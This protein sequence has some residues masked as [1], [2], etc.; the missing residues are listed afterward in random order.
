MISAKV[1][2]DDL[3][4]TATEIDGVLALVATA[5][6]HAQELRAGIARLGVLDLP[7]MLDELRQKV[8]DATKQMASAQ[9]T[10]RH[11]ADEV[12]RVIIGTGDDQVPNPQSAPEIEGT[13]QRKRPARGF[14]WLLVRALMGVTGFVILVVFGILDR[15]LHVISVSDDLYLPAVCAITLTSVSVG[16]LDRYRIPPPV[17][18]AMM[19]I[20][21]IV[22]AGGYM[23][24]DRARWSPAGDLKSD[25][26]GGALEC[27]CEAHRV[28][29]GCDQLA[30]E[31][32][33]Q[34]RCGIARIDPAVAQ[35][36]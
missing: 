22:F 1:L 15:W 33:E 18:V 11:C 35:P 10:I 16:H 28:L 24:R 23:I 2:R 19:Q 31:I 30:D 5:D 6:A 9:Q 12:H 3:T 29:A 8:D 32:A 25:G 21:G 20:F 27:P 36:L 17:E 26:G 13:P 4:E 14:D 34:P 7:L